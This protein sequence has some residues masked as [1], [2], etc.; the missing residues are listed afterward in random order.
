MKDMIISGRVHKYGNNINTD[1]ILPAQYMELSYSDIA[2]YAMEGIDPEFTSKVR[3]G[4]IIVAGKNL[5]QGRVGK[6]L[7]SL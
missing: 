7:L 1:L 5:G 2:A 6:L 3:P 4:D